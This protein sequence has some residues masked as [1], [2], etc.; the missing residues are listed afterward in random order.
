[1]LVEKIDL[2]VIWEDICETYKIPIATSKGWSS[3][4]QRAEYA[5]RFKEAEE[6][7]KTCVLLYCG[8]HDADGLRIS[9]FIRKNLREIKDI[10]WD[11]GT[12]G[13]DPKNLI[14][15]RFGLN[16]DYIVQNNLTWIDNLITGSGKNLADPSHKN[17]AL[18]YVQ[19]YLKRFG[20]RKCE[21]NALVT[22][23]AKGQA[24]CQLA[25]QKYL[26]KDAVTRFKN[27]RTE[28][29]NRF[30]EYVNGDCGLYIKDAMA[31][32]EEVMRD[33]GEEFE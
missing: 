15:D 6:D 8:D 30:E 22:N 11:D 9:D 3:V 32:L 20:P 2:K 33:N 29:Q 5:R 16:Y 14:I 24:L 25:I 18:E 17:F 10:E 27:K 19:N 23:I 12:D 1:M 28:T 4:L 7:G 26:G 21:A 31:E 13:Y